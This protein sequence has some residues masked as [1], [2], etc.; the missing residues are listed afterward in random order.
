LKRFS[1]VNIGFL[2]AIIL[3]LSFS[4]AALGAPDLEVKLN[5][6]QV[7]EGDN[8][9]VNNKTVTISVYDSNGETTNISVN[10][11]SAK[12]VKDKEFTWEASY[13]LQTGK[14]DIKILADGVESFNFSIM[15]ATL[16][17]PGLSYTASSLP[18][19]GKIE[20]LNKALTLTYPKDD[21][22]VDEDGNV[23]EGD[24]S[25][26]FEIVSPPDTNRN[27]DN[28]HYLSSPNVPFVIKITA[29]PGAYLLFPGELTLT[30]DKNVSST[31]SDQL[32]IWYSPD[33]Y[34]DDNDNSI[35]G[36]RTDTSKHTVTAPFQLN[37]HG[38][39]YYAVFLAQRQFQE[40]QG[41]DG[42][43]VSWS[44]ST[45][46]PMWAKGIAEKTTG[47]DDNSFGLL[48]DNIKR[49][50][51]AAIMVKGLALPLAKGHDHHGEEI[52]SDVDYDAEP[53]DYFGDSY[54]SSINY[55]K[56]S[57]IQYVETAAQKGIFSGYPDG[58]FKPANELTRTE[59]AVI[60]A[61]VS[62]LKLS[63]DDEKVSSDLEKIFED[64]GDI[65]L[66]AASSVLAAQKAKL[67]VGKPGQ[68]PKNLI[69]DP[70]GK[71][72]RA[73]AITVAYRLLKK[74]KKI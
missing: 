47:D 42:A 71:L 27:P 40:F 64:A 54:T 49:L 7:E 55:Y 22:L 50:E 61:R 10:G 36:G 17:V 18:A 31:I 37:E 58:L 24:Q 21:I 60:L 28:F 30:Y 44:Q 3:V 56:P 70:N 1:M 13:S 43:G 20:A 69:F 63:N 8:K 33:K 38:G 16:P 39:G 2:L 74:L 14:N 57:V 29:A 45:V 15:Y 46:L 59:A 51:F 23:W 65:P 34:W 11:K 25:I 68:D 72:S 19:S 73:E 12:S 53:E 26:T 66:W 35:L 9:L 4:Q 41:T 52:F 32:A 67:I 5:D 62:N 48:N 6:L